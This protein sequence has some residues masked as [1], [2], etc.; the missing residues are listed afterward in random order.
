M[1][2]G[3]EFES[4]VEG[5]LGITGVAMLCVYLPENNK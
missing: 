4:G 3:F 1:E 2:L 5:S